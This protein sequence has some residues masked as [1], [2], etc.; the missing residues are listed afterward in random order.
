MGT[1]LS[2][3]SDLRNKQGRENG[4]MNEHEIKSKPGTTRRLYFQDAYLREFEATVVERLDHAG[5]PAVVLDQTGFYPESGGQPSDR[6]VLDGAAV[7]LVYEEGEKIVHVLD[8]ELTASRV[9][10]HIEWPRRF[11]HMQQH[12]GQ[13]ILSQCF[14]EILNGE[15]QSFHLGEFSST[16]EIGIRTITDE[17]LEKVEGLANE[18]VFEDRE[19]KTYFISEDKIGTVPLRRPPKKEGTIRVVEVRG[20]DFSACGGTHCRRTGEI[21]LIKMI[22]W[23]K[24]RNNLRFEFQC[25]RRAWRDYALRNRLLLEISQKFS[26]QEKEAPAAVEKVVQEARQS[27]KR[28]RQLQEEL[29]GFEAREIVRRASGPIISQVWTDK[30]ADE[31][32]FLALHI[33]RAGAFA[34]LFGVK[35]GERDHLILASSEKLT[36]DMRELLPMVT[37]AMKG[38]GGGSPTLVEVVAEKGADLAAALDAAAEFLQKKLNPGA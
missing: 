10:G 12:S 38:K 30:S 28:L 6:G 21:G 4:G 14:I 36:V 37:S 23:D 32:K 26:V 5:K 15:T 8:R 2:G 19:I 16:L 13:H 20:F 27:R 34:V 35:G 9:R 11:D 24:I 25:G 1:V 18:I 33:I 29:A 17:D 31:A 22:N 7:A 3:E